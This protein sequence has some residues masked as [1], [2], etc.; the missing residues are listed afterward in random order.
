MFFFSFYRGIVYVV[1]LGMGLGVGLGIMLGKLIFLGIIL[2]EYVEK[3]F[4]YFG[5]KSV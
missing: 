1:S 3:R 4:F 5:F 2:L